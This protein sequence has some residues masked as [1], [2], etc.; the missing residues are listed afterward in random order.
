MALAAVGQTDSCPATLGDT[1][2]ATG[3]AEFR[4]WKGRHEGGVLSRFRHRDQSSMAF[5]STPQQIRR[6]E[7]VLRCRDASSS[8]PE[9]ER[10]QIKLEMSNL[11]S[12]F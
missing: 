9:K 10:I 12:I 6:P 2:D 1:M 7:P 11:Y 4:P 3:A 5:S 8:G